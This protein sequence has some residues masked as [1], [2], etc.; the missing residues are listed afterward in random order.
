ME[1]IYYTPGPFLSITSIIDVGS[2]SIYT[3]QE[4]IIRYGHHNQLFDLNVPP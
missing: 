1:H 2:Y 4:G 3:K